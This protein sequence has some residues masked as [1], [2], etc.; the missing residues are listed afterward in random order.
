MIKSIYKNLKL[1]SK[2]IMLWHGISAKGH[3]KVWNP[4]PKLW[5]S[6][7]AW[8]S[9][10]LISEAGISIENILEIG[11]PR[12][13]YLI[14]PEAALPQ[15]IEFE[16]IN[17]DKIKQS[18]PLIVFAPTF[19]RYLQNFLY[20][21]EECNILSDSLKKFDPVFD[22]RVH[23]NLLSRFKKNSEYLDTDIIFLDP[24][25]WPN[26]ES[27]LRAA[28][29]LI[30]DY[31]SIWTDAISLNIPLISINQKEV[32][33]DTNLYGLFPGIEFSSFVQFHK[34]LT[35]FD[36][37]QEF[38]Q[39]CIV[40]QKNKVGHVKE[41]LYGKNLDGSAGKRLVQNILENYHR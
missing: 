18:K 33:Y 20:F 2:C 35:S 15:D 6:S 22:V 12:T 37:I 3:L 39:H 36:S 32:S 5:I 10:L 26:T 21:I 27:I 1:E 16:V 14:C 38:I 24:I 23:P 41:L 40:F 13:D 28:D 4:P 7:G 30:T 8:E 19:N 29:L 17:L 34:F 25:N 11:S 9:S 31:S